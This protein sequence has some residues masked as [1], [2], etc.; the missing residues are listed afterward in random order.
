MAFLEA[1]LSLFARLRLWA[2][3]HG[4]EVL[5]AAVFAL[6][7]GLPL[8]VY[9]A[10]YFIDLPAYKIYVVAGSHYLNKTSPDRDTE[11]Q[12]KS[13]PELVG[14]KVDG[15]P[16]EI[17][18]VELGDDRPETAEAEARELAGKGDTLLVIGHL[19]SEPTEKS[20][21]TYFKARPQVPFI[22]SV[23]TDDNLLKKALLVKDCDGPNSSCYDGLKS[24]PYLQLSPANEEQAH[25]AVQFAAE[26]HRHHFLIVESG[27]T[28]NA[29]YSKS[30]VD[31]YKKAID[32]LILRDPSAT[33]HFLSMSDLWRNKLDEDL[34]DEDI[35]CLLYAG[36]FDDAAPLL[37]KVAE[38]EN[39]RGTV[40]EDVVSSGGPVMVI[41]DD[42]V[43]E[44]RLEGTKFAVSRVNITD[45]AD[46]ED[47]RNGISVYGLDAIAIA[48]QLVNDLNTRGL[49]LNYRV[50]AF[51]RQQTGADVRRNLVRVMQDNFTY[52]S[53]YYGARKSATASNS[54]TVYA[55]DRYT[56][57]NGMFHVWERT[58]LDSADVD[59]WHPPRTSTWAAF[60][61]HEKSKATV[62]LSASDAGPKP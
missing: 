60:Q 8:A 6:A 3:H 17:E 55:F 39:G 10:K 29:T 23:Q 33:R 15:V 12:F 19:D 30:L 28:S 26:S 5:W 7:F 40:R 34:F 22:A 57:V 24:L 31:A 49:D 47:Y 2:R 54:R 14:L 56:R 52:R 37:K 38:L 46:A 45:Q 62:E 4:G 21:P 1:A 41:L 9:F 36:G 53:A 16:V 59:R 42:S 20:L 50:K 58:G 18:V 27:D 35:D 25:W 43:V 44:Q 11:S 13:S 51:F 61:P 32:E 48:S